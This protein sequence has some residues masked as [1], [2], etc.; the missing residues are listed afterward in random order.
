MVLAMVTTGAAAQEPRPSVAVLPFENGNS[1]GH[2]KET[3]DALRRGLAATLMAELSAT[4]AVQVV[5]REQIQKLVDERQPASEKID[6]ATAARVG[7]STNARYTIA[8]T[9]TDLYGDFRIDAQIIDVGS[10]QVIKVIRSDPKLADRGQM[11]RIVQSVTDRILQAIKVDPPARG[12]RSR[13]IPTEALALYSRALLYQDRGDRQ[14]AIELYTQAVR[15]FPGYT[16]AEEGLRRL[17]GA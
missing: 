5:G 13:N 1:Y 17:R 15:S 2:D 14:R 16:E 4:G 10:G 11:Y 8:A 6:L 12:G 9:F 3:F 7:R